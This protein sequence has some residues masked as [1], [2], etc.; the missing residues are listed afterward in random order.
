VLNRTPFK[1]N[2]SSPEYLVVFEGKL[3]GEL[4]EHEYETDDV[5]WFPI[6]ELPPISRKVMKEEIDRIIEAIKTNKTIF[7]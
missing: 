5:N 6:D 7:D 3:K 1:T 2:V 4:H